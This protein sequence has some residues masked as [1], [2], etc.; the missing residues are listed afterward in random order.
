MLYEHGGRIASAK[1]QF[2]DPVFPSHRNNSILLE[3][4]S[5]FLVAE[6]PFR[7]VLPKTDASTN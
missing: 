2:I 5:S 3:T 1:V 6:M 4:N 7:T